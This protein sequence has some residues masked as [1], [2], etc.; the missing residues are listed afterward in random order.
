MSILFSSA[1]PLTPAQ[2]DRLRLLR[3]PNCLKPSQAARL[4]HGGMWLYRMQG[5]ESSGLTKETI[6]WRITRDGWSTV[7][8]VTVSQYAPELLRFRNDIEGV[9]PRHVWPF[10]LPERRHF[11]LTVHS[12]EITH[13]LGEPLYAFC[14]ALA[15]PKVVLGWPLF[16]ADQGYPGYAWTARAK[17][18]YAEHQRRC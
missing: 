1:P 16:E 8:W 4:L 11:K 17:D 10:R 3:R 13:E 18:W 6:Y 5:V 14:C 2:I 15:D 7:C 12:S 9:V